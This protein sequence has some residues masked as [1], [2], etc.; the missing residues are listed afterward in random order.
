MKTRYI[1]LLSILGVLA[2]LLS[3]YVHNTPVH[4]QAPVFDPATNPFAKGIY[5]NGI[6]ESDQ[7]SGANMNIYPEVSGTV[8]RVP[9]QE[10]QAVGKGDVLLLLDD[11]L[12]RN[13]LMVAQAQ[14]TVADASQKTAQDQYTKLK[15]AYDM[16]HDF[17]SKDELDNA[18][19][20]VLVAA[21]GVEL[22]RRQY[23]MNRVL[24]EKYTVRAPADGLVMALN[25]GVGSYVSP[26][27]VY[28]AYTGGNDPAVTMSS[29]QRNLAVRA[30]V[31]EILVARMPAPDHLYA[32]MSVRGSGVHVPLDFVRIQPYVIPK[33]DLSNGRQERVDVRVLP[34]L[35]RFKGGAGLQ[36][37]PGQLVDVYIRQQ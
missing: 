17:V 19:N 31:D 34:L 18:H 12:Q 16:N 21:A 10:G 27:G 23:D 26:Q 13:N 7:A 28:N 2:A 36:V 3:A 1:F 5:A 25:A 15:A 4:T 20:A 29:P 14:E 37:Y 24:L 6:V 33:I 9:V 22:A 32:E 11:G 8:R 30:Y 35:F